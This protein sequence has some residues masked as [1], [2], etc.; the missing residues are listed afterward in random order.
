MSRT[1]RAALTQTVNAYAPMPATVD[2]LSSLSGRLEAVRAANV[3]HHVDLLRIAAA[4][5]VRL[6]GL[7]ELFTGPYFALGTEPMWTALAE[8][9][10]TGPTVTRLRAVAAELGL[11][12]V[13]PIYELAPSG[14]RFN[15]AV[16][17]S[18]RGEILGTYRK[19]HIPHGTNEQGS[20]HEHRYYGAGDGGAG[21]PA[22][23]SGNPWFPVFE[24]AVGR[25]GVAICYDRHFEGV[26][27][28]LARGGAEV[29]LSP[30]VTFG[31][32]SRRMWPFEFAVDA[33]RHR[34]VIGGSNRRGAEPPW[35]QD[36]FGD[37]GFFGPEGRLP[38]RSDD[39]R[40]VI[41]DLPLGALAAADGSGWDL[42]RDA[43]PEI[44][45]G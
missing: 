6:V 13:A 16:V 37:S 40:L 17:L 19:N 24:T 21:G 30:A 5:G 28:A 11:V 25:V 12:V 7:G 4:Q 45:R 35:N 31:A 36:Y 2:D 18:E 1:V 26:M 33:A 34:L 39:P 3:E 38:D 42:A 23:V 15:T 8:D 41:S 32:K 27:S 29:V 43:R 22:N 10:H 9:A 20:F 14:Q 44:Y